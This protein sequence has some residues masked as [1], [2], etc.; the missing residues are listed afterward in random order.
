MEL[1]PVSIRIIENKIFTFQGKQVMVDKDLAELYEVEV[2]RLNEQVKRNVERFPSHFRF[3]LSDS[4]K[5]ELVAICDRFAT[6]KHSSSNPFVFTEHGVAMLSAVLRSK[7]A[8]M[9]SV[10]IMNAFVEMRRYLAH[11]AGL[12]QRVENIE[13]KLQL[14][15]QH[16]EKIFAAL[17]QGKPT[18]KQDIFFRGQIFDAYSFVMDLIKKANSELIIIDNYIDLS[19]LKML[20]EKSQKVQVKIITGKGSPLKA[21][22]IE[23]F[24][25]QYGQLELKHSQDFHDRFL[26]IDQRE[27][28]HIGASLKDLGKKCFAFSVIEDKKVL[29]NLMGE[30]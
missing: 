15:D 4:E 8:V 13:S 11:N 2:K 3:Q 27:L 23:K 6:L 7:K 16:F 26:I 25:A 22:D 29:I 9:V 30:L 18:I 19:I 28:Y 1:Q 17:E 10:Q 21:M 5:N 14:N 24:N 20:S 12:L